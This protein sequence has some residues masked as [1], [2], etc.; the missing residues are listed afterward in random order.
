MG[1]SG[2]TANLRYQRGG[3]GAASCPHGTFVQQTTGWPCAQTGRGE[4]GRCRSNLGR[5]GGLLALAPPPECRGRGEGE[6]WGRGGEG[7]CWGWGRGCP[8]G[9]AAMGA[10]GLGWG[11]RSPCLKPS[12]QSQGKLRLAVR[13]SSV[14]V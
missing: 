13:L 1:S 10:L 5:P 4:G 12:V 6:G 9:G 8:R 3:L 14:D 2:G 7:E 11:A